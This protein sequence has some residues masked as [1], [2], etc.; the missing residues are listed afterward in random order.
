LRNHR[1][2]F[3]C[4]LVGDVLTI[5][6]NLSRPTNAAIDLQHDGISAARH[7]G[8]RD[9]AWFKREIVPKLDAFTLSE[10]GKATGL[11]LAACSRIRAGAR[12]PHPR[13]WAALTKLIEAEE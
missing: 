4:S 1:F 11:S 2:A 6:L 7:Q 5:E 10:I 9:D 13:H 3:T 8:Q 12:V